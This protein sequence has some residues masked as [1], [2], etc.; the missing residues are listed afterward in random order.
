M[1]HRTANRKLLK[2][3][4]VT[5]MQ[6][7]QV[8]VNS[9]QKWGLGWGIR[10]VGGAKIIEHSGGGIGQRVHLAIAP[11]E[12]LAVVVLTNS[13]Q[14]IG[15]YETVVEWVLDRYRGLRETSTVGKVDP[16]PLG[17]YVGRYVQPITEVSVGRE[18][19][20]LA[21]AIQPQGSGELADPVVAPV[22]LAP[23][24]RDSFI[25]TGGVYRNLTV[26]FLR[27]DHG[28]VDFIRLGELLAPRVKDESQRK[29][30][31]VRNR[32]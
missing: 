21:L 17:D 24:G 5:M 29:G 4:T 30:H 11:E 18:D 32:P 13:I 22:A 10:F 14:G 25:I 15:L 23:I 12:D 8:S 28:G 6:Q 1:P 16:G 19:S 7:A 2:E 27:G 9:R 3:Q 20:S 26:D 31:A